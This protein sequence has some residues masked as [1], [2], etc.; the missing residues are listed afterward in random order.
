MGE[1]DRDAVFDVLRNRHR[2]KDSIDRAVRVQDE[3]RAKTE[4]TDWSGAEE[5]RRWRK[6][7]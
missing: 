2:E 7:R 5:V 3:L 6:E 1:T 4:D